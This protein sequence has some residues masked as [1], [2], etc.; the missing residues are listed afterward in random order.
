[1]FRNRFVRFFRSFFL[2]RNRSCRCDFLGQQI[3]KIRAI[4][5]I[6]WQFKVVFSE[7]GGP[8][9]CFGRS[10]V[11]KVP[12]CEGTGSGS[13]HYI[14]E[15][16]LHGNYPNGQTFMSI[17]QILM[18]FGPNRSRRCDLLFQNSSLRQNA[19]KLFKKCFENLFSHAG[20]GNVSWYT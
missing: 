15:K 7:N 10:N 6:F 1:M 11:K 17:A 20:G 2:F 13:R 9:K 14:F 4:L 3:V 18:I 19:P 16:G 5:A 12:V 8:A